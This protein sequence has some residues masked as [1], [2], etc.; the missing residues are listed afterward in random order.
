MI[1]V[2][3]LGA[4][5]TVA[6]PS[7]GKQTFPGQLLPPEAD[8]RIVTKQNG[9]KKDANGKQEANGN[10]DKKEEEEKKD[11]EGPWR[12]F[13]D[14]VAGFKVTGF[15]YGTGNVNPLNG[16][17][18]RYNGPLVLSD[19]EGVFLNQLYLSFDRAMEDHFTVGGAVTLLYGNDYNPAQS[20][21]WE[22]RPG[23]FVSPATQKWNSGQDYGLAIPQAFVEVGTKKASLVVGHFWTPIGLNVVY[24]NGNFFNTQP[25]SYMHGQP[26]DHWG[27]MAKF[28]PDD[29]WSG[30]IGVVNGWGALDR[31][32]DSASIIF[33]VKYT[34][35]E[36]KW[37]NHLHM[38]LGQEPENLGA[39]Y[40]NRFLINN[41]SWYKV[42]DCVDI[43]HEFTLGV[44]Q[45]QGRNSSTYF[46][47]SPYVYRKINDNLKAGIRADIFHDP[48]GIVAGIRN[49]NPNVGP[50]NGTFYM[51]N[52]GLNWTPNGSK[53]LMVRPEIRYDWFGGNGLP[54]DAG[55]GNDMLMLMLGAYYQF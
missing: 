11:D 49:G 25:Y 19:Q 12:M 22:L 14:P 45:N 50:Y 54:F 13:P 17:G 53:N 2:L 48:G 27:A 23:R 1:Q 39:G 21:G 41:T 20:F 33:G 38:Y 6:Q 9:D 44:Q 42:N 26:F 29:N 47:F 40:G 37:W 7:Q 32:Q 34:A 51:V 15:I 5:L 4:A 35:D 16:G 10:G 8:P 55:R 18:T 43:A 46:G 24:A 36:G 52:A 31:P 30:H 3:L 28:A